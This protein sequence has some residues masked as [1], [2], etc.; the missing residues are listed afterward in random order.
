M[1]TTSIGP[2]GT[3]YTLALFVGDRWDI[4]LPSYTVELRA[5]ASTLISSTNPVNP[6]QG[7]FAPIVLNYKATGLESGLL[8]IR[9][10]NN[11]GGQVNFDAVTLESTVPEPSSIALIGAGLIALVVRSRRK[12]VSTLS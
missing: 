12:S 7:Q 5:G 9:L 10:I 8:A 6:A 2:A 3:L 4:G 11:G 1:L